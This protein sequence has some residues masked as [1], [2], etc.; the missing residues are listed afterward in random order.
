MIILLRLLSDNRDRITVFYWSSECVVTGRNRL[1][2]STENSVGTFFSYSVSFSART[3]HLLTFSADSLSPEPYRIFFI[4]NKYLS[5]VATETR[6]VCSRMLGTM[7]MVVF[8]YDWQKNITF[9]T[10]IKNRYTVPI[11]A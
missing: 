1:I 8:V 7:C 6:F 5:I 4:S 9:G 11:I 10:P 2:T 3:L